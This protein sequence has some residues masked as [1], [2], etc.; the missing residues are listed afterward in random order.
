ME[1]NPNGHTTK[2]ATS[3]IRKDYIRLKFN[4]KKGCSHLED[5]DT[6]T[7]ISPQ[8]RAEAKQ[9]IT[10]EVNNRVKQIRVNP[11]CYCWLFVIFLFLVIG[12]VGTSF[13]SPY[14][15]IFMGLG[16][17]GFVV[18][19]V[20]VLLKNCKHA[21]F[22]RKAS[23]EMSRRT[24]GQM[25]LEFIMKTLLF[26]MKPNARRQAKCV[27]ILLR[28]KD[29][30]M[31]IKGLKAVSDKLVV[32]NQQQMLTGQNNLDRAGNVNLPTA[33]YQ[34]PNST[35]VQ[36]LPRNDYA[37]PNHIHNINMGQHNGGPI[38]SV[39]S[40]RQPQENYGK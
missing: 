19:L 8:L 13:M 39:Q 36:Q 16:F 23:A 38:Y 18:F 11:M 4:Y 35:N 30:K 27:A 7:D 31:R 37:P 25:I 5:I 33:G 12:I 2:P 26:N 28:H 21:A 9:V 40:Q 29:S 3:K 34:Q 22:F 14:N 24:G 1:M 15:F 20:F 17:V 10:E 6:L 32:K